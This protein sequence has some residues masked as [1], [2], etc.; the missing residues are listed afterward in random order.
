MWAY[1]NM[2]DPRWT[3]GEKY[4]LLRQDPAVAAPQ[5]IGVRVTDGWAAYANGGRLFVK[6][7]A[8]DPRGAYPDWGCS[9]ET[10][11]NNDMIELETLGPVTTIAP[12]ARVEHVETWHLFK[13]VK[14]PSDD[15]AVDASV[16][17][18]VKSA[19]A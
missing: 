12:G 8:V 4:I 17:P 5:K 13:D 10:F 16:L 18:R 2:A 19:R 14:V 7:F 6:T 9:V 15:A 3:W 11:T 1:T